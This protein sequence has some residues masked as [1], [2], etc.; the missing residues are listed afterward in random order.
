MTF[1]SRPFIW[2]PHFVYPKARTYP[3]YST[4]SET[5]REEVLLL[6]STPLKK[7]ELL[8]KAVNV[9]TLN[10]ILAHYDYHYGST[11]A[12]YWETVPQSIEAGAHQWARY[13]SLTHEPL[14]AGWWRVTISLKSAYT[15]T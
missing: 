7:W 5:I 10:A 9:A 8:F 6:D 11:Y 13:E 4:P 1:S 3:S 12:F 15:T 14:G 2:N